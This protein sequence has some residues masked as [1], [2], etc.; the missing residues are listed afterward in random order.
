MQ[1]KR[2]VLAACL[3]FVLSD[4]AFAD[5]PSAAVETAAPQRGA[6]AQPV[7][8]YGVVA[9]ASGNLISVSLPYVARVVRLLVQAG[10]RVG[11]GAPLVVVQADPA[12]A[13]GVSQARGAAALAGDDARRTQSLFDKG[14]ATASQLAT[15]KK[16]A[17]DAHDALAAQE[18][19]G[20]TPGS[21][22]VTA[23]AQGVVLQIQA[24]EGDQMAAGAP[25]LQLTSAST[26]RGNVLLG[27][28]PGDAAR[29]HA[30]DALTLH[31]LST[32]LAD[33][34]LSGHVALVGA[35]IDP[36]TQLVDVTADVPLTGTAFI[37]GMRVGA[38]ISTAS[39]EHWIVPRAAML[40]DGKGAYVYQIAPGNTARRVNVALKTEDGARYG[41]D[42]PIDAAWP[43]V[44]TGNYELADGMTVRTTTPP[45]GSAAR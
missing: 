11:R 20:A 44:V 14:L 19:L 27:V 18:A 43:L 25:I 4:P 32:A 10:Q 33:A 6:I 31:G 34:S 26:A 1:N 8:A 41:V 39:G 38:D 16:A 45:P 3:C 2:F 17:Q 35:A 23:P 5:T 22:T 37:P 24:S 29:I 28:E 7:R 21:K 40:R 30:G 42:G 9:A 13:L 12:A 15:A 36:Q